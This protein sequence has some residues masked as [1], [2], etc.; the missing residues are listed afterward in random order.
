MVP[1][2]V[3]A[4]AALALGTA[5]LALVLATIANRRWAS[6][7]RAVRDLPTRS[8][9]ELLDAHAALAEQLTALRTHLAGLADRATRHEDLIR[10]AQGTL[11]ETVDR[12]GLA[13][14]TAADSRY[15]SDEASATAADASATAASAAAA[16][17]AA[18][19]AASTASD[20]TALRHV[21]IVRY[22]AYADVGGR[23]SYSVALLDDTRSGLV[24]TTLSGKADVRTYV[25]AVSG[26][27]GDGTLT[28][29][30]QQAVTAAAA[31]VPG[32]RS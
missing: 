24:L 23:L 3:S 10:E 16:A 7:P 22:D 21:A 4:I 20:P 32:S 12:L 13:E 27:V 18:T 29:E 9:S 31:G 17:A 1:G 30:E 8:D 5:I 25:R 28:D 6:R 14:A 26:G 19:T 15:R 11:H 2:W